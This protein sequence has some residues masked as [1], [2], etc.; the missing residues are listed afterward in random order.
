MG[1]LAIL[2]VKLLNAEIQN[3]LHAPGRMTVDLK[4]RNGMGPLWLLLLVLLSSGTNV[5]PGQLVVIKLQ[6][7]VTSWAEPLLQDAILGVCAVPVTRD[8]RDL[9]LWSPPFR[10]NCQRAAGPVH[11]VEMGM[12]YVCE[13]GR[14]LD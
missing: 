2:S 13:W 1:S 10:G 11:S 8:E 12:L 14:E 6:H 4:D 5:S 7:R 3:P 9:S